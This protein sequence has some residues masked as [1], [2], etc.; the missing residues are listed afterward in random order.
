MSPNDRLALV[1]KEFTHLAKAEAAKARA[2]E[3]ANKAAEKLAE[4][5]KEKQALLER[6]EKAEKDKD[7]AEKK[8][9]ALEEAK[10]GKE[11]EA[12]PEPKKPE[13]KAKPKD[14]GKPK[15][16]ED[17]PE[18]TEEECIA[19]IKKAKSFREIEEIENN[20]KVPSRRENKKELERHKPETAQLKKKG[21]R[22][23]AVPGSWWKRH[24]KGVAACAILI[25]VAVVVALLWMHGHHAPVPTELTQIKDIVNTP[26]APAAPHIPGAG[27]SAAHQAL[28]SIAQ[29]GT[30]AAKA[31]VVNVN[32]TTGVAAT[33]L[34]GVGS[35]AHTVTTVNPTTGVAATSY[36]NPAD[37]LA[38][39]KALQ[40][41]N[42]NEATVTAFYNNVVASTAPQPT[43]VNVIPNPEQATNVLSNIFNQ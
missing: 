23:V 38:H 33:N 26:P 18:M 42:V 19:A 20:N 10:K 31:G 4:V 28:N 32:P 34:S 9:K 5:E 3:E 1:H 6:A 40:A 41:G 24:K 30:G 21:E 8:A 25:G 22:V 29:T 39:A 12:K 35:V 11:A 36:G 14:D 43:T 17:E 13:P 15:D 27:D 7:V 37:I 16:D 2:A